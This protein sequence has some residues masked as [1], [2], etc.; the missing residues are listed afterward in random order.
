M[1][2]P[3]PEGHIPINLPPIETPPPIDFEQPV[4]GSEAP[5]DNVS[6]YLSWQNKILNELPRNPTP[7]Q[8]LDSQAEFLDMHTRGLQERYNLNSSQVRRIKTNFKEIV[9]AHYDQFNM[10]DDLNSPSTIAERVAREIEGMAD[11]LV[12]QEANVGIASLADAV[13][14]THLPLPTP[15][16]V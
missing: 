10:A 5:P 3:A 7:Q 16:Y 15:P 1:G 8:F 9:A 4:L 11:K 6:N 2:P 14:Y 12:K 13:S